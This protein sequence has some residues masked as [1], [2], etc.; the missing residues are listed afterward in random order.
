MFVAGD[1]AASKP[2]VLA[3]VESTGFEGVD[4]GLLRAA[5]L[6]EPLAKLW[7]G[8]GRLRGWGPDSALTLQ[9]KA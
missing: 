2:T 1:D 6:L 7:I 3:L 5:R 8:L 9:R 4:A